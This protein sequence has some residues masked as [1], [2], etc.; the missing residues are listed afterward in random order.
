MRVASAIMQALTED[1]T[2]AAVQALSLARGSA[3][4]NQFRFGNPRTRRHSPSFCYGM[5]VWLFAWLEW[6]SGMERLGV[7]QNSFPYRA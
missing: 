5:A 2:G 1:G 4:P 3:L 7:D 6:A